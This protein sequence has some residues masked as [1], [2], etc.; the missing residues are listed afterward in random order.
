MK[1]VSQPWCDHTAF[2]RT[3][4]SCDRVRRAWRGQALG[5]TPTVLSGGDGG[6]VIDAIGIGSSSLRADERE[7][8]V[9]DVIFV[10]VSMVFFIASIGYVAACERLMK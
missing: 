7:D 5:R 3:H 6:R 9:L 2:G 8:D 1:C 10:A 4:S